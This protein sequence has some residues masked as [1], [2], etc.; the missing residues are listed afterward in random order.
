MN[1]SIKSRYVKSIIVLVRAKFDGFLT[2]DELYKGIV[3]MNLEYGKNLNIMP[4]FKK[5]P[6][7]KFDI[8]K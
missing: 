3:E 1:K 5:H 7:L 4:L 8:V 6:E 2:L